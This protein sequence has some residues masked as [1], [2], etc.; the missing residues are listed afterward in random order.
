MSELLVPGVH[1]PFRDTLCLLT[2]AVRCAGPWPG[3]GRTDLGSAASPRIA[4]LG[5]Q[6]LAEPLTPG[7]LPKGGEGRVN[8]KLQP[9][10]QGGAGRANSK[11]Q[12]SPLC[13][14]GRCGEAVLPIAPGEGDRQYVSELTKASTKSNEPKGLK[15]LA[16]NKIAHER[17]KNKPKL[18][19]SHDI[20][21][22]QRF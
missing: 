14:R 7:L 16:I 3:L 20:N 15:M 11:L 17:Q 1:F 6:G 2:R 9:S 13:G 12:P 5:G 4:P 19:I 22:L 21:H 8:W 10:P 18:V